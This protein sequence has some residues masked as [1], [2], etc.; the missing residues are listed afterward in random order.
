MEFF[1]LRASLGA[2]LRP[3]ASANLVRISCFACLLLCLPFCLLACLV[4][5]LLLG[6]WL[7]GWRA[8]WLTRSL[9]RS[10][11]R[12][13]ARLLACAVYDSDL[14]SVPSIALLHFVPPVNIPIPTKIGSQMGGAPIPKWDPKTVLTT[15]AILH[16]LPAKHFS[17][18]KNGKGGQS[19]SVLTHGPRQFGRRSSRG[20]QPPAPPP[21]MPVSILSSLRRGVRRVHARRALDV[22]KKL[23]H[24]LSS[25]PPPKKVQTLYVPLKWSKPKK[26]KVHELGDDGLL[27]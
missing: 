17:F 8:G 18:A 23:T 21:S 25:W 20:T 27:I 16:L 19:V 2:G 11:A 6:R 3:W 13:L 24:L 7:P 5:C 1:G 4:A 22:H 14:L 12:L 26:F 10:L 15:T 9:A